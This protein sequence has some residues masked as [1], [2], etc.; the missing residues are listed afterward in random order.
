MCDFT[1]SSD[2]Y[3]RDATARLELPAATHL[4]TSSSRAD[5]DDSTM[6]SASSAAISGGM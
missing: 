2:R 1:V 5:K 6:C 4:R 3:I